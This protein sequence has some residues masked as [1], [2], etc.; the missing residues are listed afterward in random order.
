M[1]AHVWIND[2]PLTAAAFQF[3]KVEGWQD[4]LEIRP[5]SVAIPGWAGELGT[6][7]AAAAPRTIVCTGWVFVSTQAGLVAAI[8]Q[9]KAL[10]GAGLS[11]V[12]FVDRLDRTFWAQ[13]TRW[14]TTGAKAVQFNRPA[15]GVELTFTCPSPAGFDQVGRTIAFSATPAQLSLGSAPVAPIIRIFAPAGSVTNPTLTYRD[16]AGNVRGSITL[17]QILATTDWLEVNMDTQVITRSLSGVVT[18]P[19][20]IAA[21]T[22]FALDPADGDVINGV[23][24]TLEVTASAGAPTGLALYR[25]TYQ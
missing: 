4:G 25:R 3:E 17:T 1:T 5:A 21:G 7:L 13:L 10:A 20:P 9:V 24:P 2:Y 22:F 6:G 12:R 8:D 11:E 14:R 18:G 23:G 15:R 19:V 16:L